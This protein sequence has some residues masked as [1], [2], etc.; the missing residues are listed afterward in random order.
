[1]RTFFVLVYKELRELLTLQMLGPF[2]AVIVIFVVL[3]QVISSAGESAGTARAVLVDR[4]GTTTSVAIASSLESVGMDLTYIKNGDTDAAV[5]EY[6]PDGIS[7][8][9]TVPEGFEDALLKGEPDALQVRTV[10][11]DFS[12][13]GFVGTAQMQAGLA[14]ASQQLAATLSAQHGIDVPIAL[15]Q[16]PLRIDESVTIG[17]RTAATSVDAVSGFIGQQTFFIPIVLFIVIVFASQL[18]A[19]TIATE[20]E[21]KTLET[22]LSYPITRTALVTA[23]MVAAGLVSLLAAGAYMVGMQQY[24][25]GITTGVSGGAEGASAATQEVM[26]QLGLV[27]GPPDY[28]MLGLSLFAGILLA[29][30]ISIILGAFAESV[31]AVGALMT[32]LM[33][34]L[35]VPY[36]LTMFVNLS[37]AP[38]ALRWGLLAIPFTHPFTAAQNLFLGKEGTVWLGIGYQLAWFVAFALIAARIFSS[39]RILTMKLNLR[40]KK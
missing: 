15:L 4:D 3:G 35:M 7:L 9:L 8:F 34:L 17:D 21:N 12:V 2:L 26:Q 31:K 37:T 38:S 39:D 16:Q 33:A 1:M 19:T 32:P 5:A 30:A 29:L 36:L 27:L 24:M 6:A 23:K 28:V 13:L 20:K 40:R 11:T 14:A 25:S 18:I 22:L 10:M